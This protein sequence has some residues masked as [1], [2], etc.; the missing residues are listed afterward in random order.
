LD[1]CWEPWVTLALSRLKKGCVAV[2]IGANQG[3]YTLLLADLCGKAVA[4]EPQE[5]LTP[6]IEQSAKLNGF[7]E[8]VQVLNVA[9][10]KEPGSASLDFR[11]DFQDKCS[12]RVK[13]ENGGGVI[14]ETLDSLRFEERVGFIKLDAEGMEPD[15]WEGARGLLAHMRPTIAMEFSPARYEDPEGFLKEIQRWYS[16]Q[17]ID[18]DG[19]LSPVSLSKVLEQ[20]TM[21][22]LE[23][24]DV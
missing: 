11:G 17:E 8:R 13:E 9:L 18:V 19:G 22:W 23:D 21:L 24:S 1:G 5:T 6:F 4:C 20:E 2:D 7:Q 10:G 3:Y 12:V 15:I 14:V 16:L